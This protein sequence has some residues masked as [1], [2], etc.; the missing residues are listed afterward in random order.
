MLYG[1][2]V[3]ARRV[4]PAHFKRLNSVERYVE[5]ISTASVDL[6]G[7]LELAAVGLR[8]VAVKSELRVVT[9]NVKIHLA[10]SLSDFAAD[11]SDENGKGSEPYSVFEL[12]RGRVLAEPEIH[13]LELHSRCVVY[14]CKRGRI[15]RIGFFVYYTAIG[16]AP[17]VE[18]SG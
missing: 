17:V 1:N 9:V 16:N 4:C 8:H 6:C 2:K 15:N 10:G 13:A 14:R 5:L 18:M 3:V 12:A 7:K 11:E